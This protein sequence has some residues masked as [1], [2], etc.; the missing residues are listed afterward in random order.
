VEVP[1]TN[2]IKGE[3]IAIKIAVFNFWMQDIEVCGNKYFGR[4]MTSEDQ[5]Q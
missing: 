4:E 5:K 2:V 3:Q 1:E